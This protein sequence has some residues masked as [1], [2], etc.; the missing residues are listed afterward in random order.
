[1]HDFNARRSQKYGTATESERHEAVRVVDVISGVFH[2]ALRCLWS[3]Q[4]LSAPAL[5]Y[6]VLCISRSVWR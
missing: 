2:G 3:R 5:P 6:H 1:M 4:T